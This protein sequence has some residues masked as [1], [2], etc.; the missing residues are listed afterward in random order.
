MVIP[1]MVVSLL[2][3][4]ANVV[5]HHV[6]MVWLG[7][8]VDGAG[9][10]LSM[11]GMFLL[12]VLVSFS[13]IKRC[14]LCPSVSLPLLPSGDKRRTAKQNAHRASGYL[15]LWKS[16]GATVVYTNRL[17]NLAVSI[18][19]SREKSRRCSCCCR[20]CPRLDRNRQ[21]QTCCCDV[22]RFVLILAVVGA[23]VPQ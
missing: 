8:G 9:L 5:F 16:G 11:T 21:L 4:V 2:G 19:R 1:I 14:D 18:H 22:F 13:W 10:A 3:M 7:M 23:V 17:L 15:R 6:T 12:V 20:R